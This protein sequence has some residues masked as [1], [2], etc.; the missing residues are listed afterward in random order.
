MPHNS[1]QGVVV[2]ELLPARYAEERRQGICR[3]CL[4]PIW[5]EGG[6]VGHMHREE[7]WSDRVERGGD[8]LV[9]FKA[10]HY[11]HV[12]LDGREAAIYDRAVQR[13]V[14]AMKAR[15]DALAEQVAKV[16]EWHVMFECDGPEEDVDGRPLPGGP[17]F[18]EACE[19]CFDGDMPARWPCPT[20]AALDGRQ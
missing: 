10:A 13:G 17:R 3:T 16:R 2:L 18:Y 12:P 11:R 7:G 19:T 5:D 9:C 6:T 4:A 20:I 1:D 15:A 14:E 8:S